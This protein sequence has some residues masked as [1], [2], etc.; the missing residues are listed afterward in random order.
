[1]VGNMYPRNGSFSMDWTG[2]A[3]RTAA[4]QWPK[5]SGDED[6]ASVTA[7][8]GGSAWAVGYFG[9][10]LPGDKSVIFHWSGKAW[11]VAWQLAQPAGYLPGIAVVSSTDA[12]SI[13]YIC[14][15]TNDNRCD[16]SQYLAL[17]WNGR[18]W[19]ESW[20]PASFQPAG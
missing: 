6:L 9:D 2:K 15:A 13:G 3:W 14:V 18:T 16:K 7:I 11:T 19:N 12:W 1:G 17:H 8:P 10:P 20:L 5:P 4:I